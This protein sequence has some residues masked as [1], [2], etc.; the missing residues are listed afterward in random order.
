M[1]LLFS[2]SLDCVSH[3]LCDVLDVLLSWLPLLVWSLVGDGYGDGRRWLPVN[4]PLPGLGLAVY[5]GWPG[6]P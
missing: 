6:L 4:L 5:P 1:S 2:P 3:L